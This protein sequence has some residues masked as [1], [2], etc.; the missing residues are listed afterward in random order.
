MRNTDQEEVGDDDEEL[1]FHA[2]ELRGALKVYKQAEKIDI[3]SFLKLFQLLL[4]IAPL[5]RAE[6]VSLY[7]TQ[8]LGKRLKGLQAAS[9]TSWRLWR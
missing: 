4:L 8:L 3:G 5:G 9:K 2:F 6:N 7:T 1:A